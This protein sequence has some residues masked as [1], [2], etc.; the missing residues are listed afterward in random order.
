MRATSTTTPAAAAEGR[1][2]HPHPHHSPTP[3]T[4]QFLPPITRAA[5]IGLSQTPWKVQLSELKTNRKKAVSSV[6]LTEINTPINRGGGDGRGSRDR[7]RKKKKKK[8][9]RSQGH[10]GV[11]GSL[12]Q[13]WGRYWRHGRIQPFWCPRRHYGLEPPPIGEY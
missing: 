1:R 7:G 6:T 4:C 2:E 3:L 12:Q 11:S 5:V 13:N 10:T 8:K 9:W